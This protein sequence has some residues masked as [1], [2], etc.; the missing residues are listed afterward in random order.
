[1]SK[2]TYR[3]IK[4]LFAG[5]RLAKKLVIIIL[6]NIPVN[7]NDMNEFNPYKSRYFSVFIFYFIRLNLGST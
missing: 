4:N 1:M 3:I 5:R 7:A 6:Y 2:V